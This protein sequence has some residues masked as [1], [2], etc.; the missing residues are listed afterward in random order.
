MQKVDDWSIALFPFHLFILLFQV[1]FH[2]IF[3]SCFNFPL[4]YFS[5]SLIIF[6]QYIGSSPFATFLPL[7]L[8]S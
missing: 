8:V 1:L 4:Q 2:S 5:L 6:T 3:G 7:P